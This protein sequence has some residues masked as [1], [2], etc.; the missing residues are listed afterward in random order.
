M[1]SPNN[2]RV[3]RI[4]AGGCDGQYVH[5]PVYTDASL[6]MVC[7]IWVDTL[8]TQAPTPAGTVASTGDRFSVKCAVPLGDTNE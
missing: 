7:S 2:N 4:D 6:G 1:T 5:T 3:D 8:M